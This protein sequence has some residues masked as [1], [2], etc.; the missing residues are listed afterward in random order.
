[1]KIFIDS[2]S[3]V[4][5]YNFE[6]G[7]DKLFH[8]LEKTTEVY[9]SHIT[10]LETINTFNRRHAQ[11]EIS[12]TDLNEA[13]TKLNHDLQYFSTISW[14]DTLKN[15]CIKLVNKYRLKT[16]DVIQIGS[17]VKASSRLFVTSDKKQSQIAKKEFKE[18]LLIL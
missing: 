17:A 9:V 13:L 5:K 16:L 12:S 14:D 6:T 11:K 15:L 7:T 4:K 18:I 8:L 3:L 2:S 1:M 10:Y